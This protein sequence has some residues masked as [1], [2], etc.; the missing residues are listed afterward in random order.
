[1][2]TQGKHFEWIQNTEAVKTA[3]LSTQESTF[4]TSASGKGNG[5]C[6]V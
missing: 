6:L 1:M 5:I 4:R 3:Q 2:A